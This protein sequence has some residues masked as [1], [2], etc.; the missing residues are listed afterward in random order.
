MPNP[1]YLVFT[2]G[3][4]IE[5]FKHGDDYYIWDYTKIAF[6]DQE[7]IDTPIDRV[8]PIAGILELALARRFRREQ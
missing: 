7:K 2:N 3:R 5:A 1:T 4:W 6:G 8:I